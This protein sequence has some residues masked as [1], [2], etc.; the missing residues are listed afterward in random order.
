M[1]ENDKPQPRPGDWY[2]DIAETYEA[3]ADT[4]ATSEHGRTANLLEA[5]KYR[6]IGARLDLAMAGGDRRA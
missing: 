2:R 5:A 6:A 1:P 4:Y 3:H